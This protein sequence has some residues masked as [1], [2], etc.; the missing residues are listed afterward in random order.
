MSQ[1]NILRPMLYLTYTTDIPQ[2]EQGTITTFAEDTAIL[3]LGKGHEETA[4]KLQMSINQI[5][6]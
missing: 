5:N 6:N 1:G 3:A 2:L 4:T